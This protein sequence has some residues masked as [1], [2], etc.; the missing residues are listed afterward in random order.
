M[1]RL[2]TGLEAT[3]EEHS[4]KKVLLSGVT[5]D[6]FSFGFWDDPFRLIGIPEIYLTPG[7]EKTIAPHPEWGGIS[8]FIIPLQ[9][10][11]EALNKDQAV[12]YSV[13]SQGIQNVTPVFKVML[14]AQLM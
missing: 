11:V 12:V 6:L 13:D 14:T 1:K 5:N 7:S 3:S 8:R 2:V 9:S 10:A 4:G